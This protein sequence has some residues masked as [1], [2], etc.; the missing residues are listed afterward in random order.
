MT[1]PTNLY[2]RALAANGT[3]APEDTPQLLVHQA[4]V[5]EMMAE[6]S[7]LGAVLDAVTGALEDLLPG[8]Q[9]SVLLLDERTGTLHH[10]AAP[11]M[12]QAYIDAIDGMD[13]GP[14]AGSCGTAVHRALPVVVAD[15]DSSPLWEDFRPA[16]AIAG[17]RA[18]WS[19]PI[20][21]KDGKVLGTFAVYHDVPH[22]PSER[23]R[24]L[25]D[26]FTHL[27]AVAI[28]HERLFGSLAQSEE[29]FRRAFDDN[30]AGMALLALD[31]RVVRVNRALCA[32]LRTE[33]PGLV[34]RF[35]QDLVV[36]EDRPGLLAGA[37]AGS[38]V[39][40]RCELRFRRPSADPL[41]AS[42]TYSGVRD[43]DGR[44]AS[45]CVNLVDET[46]RKAAEEERRARAEAVIAQQ[47]AE[48]NSRTKSQFLTALGHEIRTPLH[49]VV[50]FAELLRS[51][52]LPP[53]RQQ[54]AL[55]RMSSASKHLVALVDDLSDV[56][57]IEARALRLRTAPVPLVP[58]VTD[59]H[60]LLSTLAQDAE[61]AFDTVCPD[62]D[63]VAV[64]D[65]RRLRQ[66][67]LN[68]ATNAIKYNAPGGR[69]EL[70]IERR[71]GAWRLVV[72]DDGPGIPPHLQH[73][74]FVPF[75]RLGAERTKN[76]GSGL[77][78]HVTK[79]L[80][81]GMGGTLAI[82]SDGA[83]NGTVAHVTLPAEVPATPAEGEPG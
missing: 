79:G 3:V 48:E 53:E 64:C 25:V 7:P 80:V 36:P 23:E 41:I 35:F 20:P 66:V 67:L 33:A 78:L 59:V 71:P 18:C 26:R 12:P 46:D 38:C 40:H 63:P 62:G 72:E 51:G 39:T 1:V 29:R 82:E 56:A 50:G 28:D 70:R 13:T 81:D 19:T 34:G 52:T 73:R 24:Y 37:A 16:A 77:G 31:G 42:T 27:S 9:C 32:L 4:Q 6:G 2:R 55:E 15:I 43:A 69:V 30:A 21:G 57:A 11:S 58:L 5:L 14:C 54:Q 65:E 45:W 61:V 83:D 17:V 44:I 47:H 75:D 10:G 49:A 8:T 74:L 22:T 68:L 76:P 60:G